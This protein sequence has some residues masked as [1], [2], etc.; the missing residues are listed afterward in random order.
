MTGFRHCR[1]KNHVTALRGRPGEKKHVTVPR[2]RPSEKKTCHSSARPARRKKTCHSFAGGYRP[3][4]CRFGWASTGKPY[5]PSPAGLHKLA[6]G[7]KKI[8]SQLWPGRPA[9][10]KNVTAPDRPGRPSE[11]NYVTAPRG[12][13]GPMKNNVTASGPRPRL[14]GAV[15]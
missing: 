13:P 7:R 8:M 9:R 11:T 5:R 1:R 6:S 2:G 12:R 4:P 10:K 3:S 14:P 15:T